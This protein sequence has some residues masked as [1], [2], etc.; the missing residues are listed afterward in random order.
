VVKDSFGV[1]EVEVFINSK[2]YTYP[3]TSEF[4]L[5]KI[6]KLL[7]LNKPGKALYLLKL[8]KVSG[9]NNF[10]TERGS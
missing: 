7:R 10:E 4:A 8:F 9:F 2:L 3:I 6:G 5:R 1:Y